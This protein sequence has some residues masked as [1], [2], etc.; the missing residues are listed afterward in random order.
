MPVKQLSSEQLRD[1]QDIIFRLAFLLEDP[2]GQD[3]IDLATILVDL[4]VAVP[5]HERVTFARAV[6]ESMKRTRMS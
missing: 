2:C 3:E 1:R 6:A 5:P 4:A